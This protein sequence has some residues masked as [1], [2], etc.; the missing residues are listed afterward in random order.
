VAR[1]VP[2]GNPF[3]AGPVNEIWM[4]VGPTRAQTVHGVDIPEAAKVRVVY[5]SANRDGARFPDP[6]EFRIERPVREL[7]SHLAFATGPHACLGSALARTELRVAL[8]TIFKRLSGL[9][10]DPDRVASA[11]LSQS[12]GS[13]LPREQP[14]HG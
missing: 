14:T 10:L 9:D 13:F 5:A 8:E 7:R 3:I 4:V 2:E 1:T 12:L 6:D 11:G